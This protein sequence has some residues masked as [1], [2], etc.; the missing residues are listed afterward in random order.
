MAVQDWQSGAY[1]NANPFRIPEPVLLRTG[2]FIIPIDNR[3]N[4]GYAYNTYIPLFTYRLGMECFKHPRTIPMLGSLVHIYMKTGEY[5][6]VDP[7]KRLKQKGIVGTI[8]GFDW[9][10]VNGVQVYLANQ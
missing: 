10:T 6:R 5:A 7:N 2:N 9:S 3:I 1:N 4:P 8:P